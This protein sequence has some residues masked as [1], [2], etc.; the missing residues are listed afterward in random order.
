MVRHNSK[1]ERL[2]PCISK[3][4]INEETNGFIADKQTQSK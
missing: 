3:Q 1:I 4:L 2:S